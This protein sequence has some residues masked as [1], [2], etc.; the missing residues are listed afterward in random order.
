MMN[1]YSLSAYYELKRYQYLLYRY[2]HVQHLW[3][4]KPNKVSRSQRRYIKY[5]VSALYAKFYSERDELGFFIF[6][7]TPVTRCRSPPFSNILNENEM[8]ERLE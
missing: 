1:T 5:T 6:I 8:L 4:Q 2:H 7:G 3:S